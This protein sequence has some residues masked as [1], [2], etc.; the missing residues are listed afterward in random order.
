MTATDAADTS[1]AAA[2]A[3][4]QPAADSFIFVGTAF[5]L[6]RKNWG[7]IV[8]RGVALILLGVLA[9]ALPG[10]TLF[11]FVLL[12]AAFSFVDGLF[13]IVAAVRGAR[14]SS[15]RWGALLLS[16]L[17]GVAIGALF[18]LF[19]VLSTMAFAFVSVVLI[20]AWAGIN[21]VMQILAAIRLRKTIEGEWLLALSGVLSL[22]LALA[23]GYVAV[24]EPAVTALTVAWLIGIYALI[25][26]IA[27]VALGIRLRP[28]AAADAN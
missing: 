20:G 1:A 15:E 19:P 9:F 24:T 12:F 23:I 4:T 10:P 6:P 16:G 18:V 14:H 2:S 28:A 21:G 17:V 13:S 7:W 27:L 3:R 5:V 8:A 22:L 11:A 26:G 25:G